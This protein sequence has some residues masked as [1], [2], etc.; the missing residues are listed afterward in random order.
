MSWWLV[1]VAPAGHDPEDLAR[2]VAELTGQTALESADRVVGYAADEPS[3][4]SLLRVLADR[5]PGLDGRVF[6]EAAVDWTTAWREG[7][8]IREVG[9]LQ[10]G[11]SWLLAPGPA[12]VVI[13]PEMAF[14]SG[15]HGS[16]RGALTLLHRYL[17]AGGTV[18]DLGSGSGI[19]TIAAVKLGARSALGVEVDDEAVPIADANAALNLV[20]DRVRFVVADA[21][22]IAPLAG[23]ADLVVSNILR[24]ANET[25]LP[26][27]TAALAA[28]G[29][30]IFAG[31]EANEADLFRPAL[32][33]AGLVPID[34]LVD[35]GWWSVAARRA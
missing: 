3:A 5:F 27:I 35:E 9:G 15:E 13:D 24:T 31:M 30:A 8:G 32:L 7:L 19:L 1:E 23:P 29:V 28:D 34:E 16:T 17:R 12:T 21:G 10:L 2:A 20:A 25:L 14:G 26:A 18:L 22:V 4:R 33:G 11:P 6:Q